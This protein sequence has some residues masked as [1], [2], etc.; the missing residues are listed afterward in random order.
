MA[1]PR[2]DSTTEVITTK[3]MIET[4]H[5]DDIFSKFPPCELYLTM[6]LSNHESPPRF[7]KDTN[8]HRGQTDVKSS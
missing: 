2:I 5:R 4:S 1:S 6:R 8:P 3:K 7:C